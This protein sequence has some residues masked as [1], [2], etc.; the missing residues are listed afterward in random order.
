MSTKSALKID[1]KRLRKDIQALSKI[2]YNG[3]TRGITRQGL[4]RA[5]Y[6]G[7]Q[8]LMEQFRKIELEPTMDGACNV[9]CRHGDSRKPSVILGSHL[10]TVPDAGMFDGILGV[11]AGLECLRTIKENGIHLKRPV[12]VVAFSEEEGRFGGMFGVQAF[13]GNISPEWIEIARDADGFLLRDEMRKLGM[14]PQ[15]AL[16]AYREPES[17]HAYL[18]LH[19]EQGP[20]LD[21]MKRSIGIVEG[22][23]GV[24]DWNIRIIGAANHAG[25]TPME[26]RR[27]AFLGLSDFAHEIS[28]IIAENGTEL[29]R[30]TIGKVNIKPGFVHVVPGEVEFT[31]TGRELDE[32]VMWELAAACR[33]VLSAIARQNNLMFEYEEKSWLPP[34][35]CS[36]Q[37]MDVI[38]Q[39]TEKLGY[40]YHTLP[41]GAGHDAQFMADITDAGMIF[42]PSVGGISHSPK[43]WTNW[44]DIEKGANVLLHSCLELAT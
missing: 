21:D 39:N 9:I 38:R 19:I 5:D 6:E 35:Y 7:R 42:V 44:A 12:E 40:K 16:T 17:I 8:W 37:I 36:P 41:S 23:S 33:K 32:A 25:T 28:R 18:E 15:D 24:F 27:D 34:K 14:N 43:E 26:N 13:C 22:I 11:L 30:L 1:I 4:T 2:G 31:L 10:D 20:V 29:S 3:E